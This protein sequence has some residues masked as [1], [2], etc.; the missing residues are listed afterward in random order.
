MIEANWGDTIQV[1]V[2]NKIENPEEG[3]TLHWHGLMQQ[4]TQWEDG[5][6]AVSQ[7]PIP[8]G[9][10]FTYSFRAT[11]HGSTWYHSHYSSQYAGGLW[12]PMVIYGPETRSHDVDIG[13]VLLTDYFHRGYFDIVQ[14]IEGTDLSLARPASDN[15]LINGKMNF[16]CSNNTLGG[17][18]TDGAGLSKFNFTSGKSHRLRL[19]NAGVQGIQKFSIDNHTMTVIA[20]DFI[21]VNPYN[22]TVV[23]LGV[24]V[25]KS[26]ILGEVNDLSQVGQ[27]SDVIVQGTGHSGEVYWMRSLLAQGACTE[28]ANQPLAL[29]A[30]YYQNANTS[31]SPNPKTSIAQ[32]D[33]TDPCTNDGMAVPAYEIPVADPSTTINMAVNV[34]VNAT[35]HLVWTINESSFRGNYNNPLLLLARNGNDSY[36]SDPQWNVYNVGSNQTIRVVVENQSPTSHP[37]HLHGHEMQVLSSG[38]GPWDGS[39]TN[40][41]N[42]NRRDVQILP[43]YGHNVSPLSLS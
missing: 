35:G 36:P 20:N 19:V 7:C 9:Q 26:W 6:P 34:S 41:N 40:A 14:D 29:A 10:S 8:P 28:P 22:A 3:T 31:A 32:A 2:N 23:T 13:P 38:D 5:V 43:A 4:K 27:R 37:W 24:S 17:T 12:G 11:P 42:P 16:D 1:T 15:N 33:T 30:I 25:Q 39:I 18:C 21:Q